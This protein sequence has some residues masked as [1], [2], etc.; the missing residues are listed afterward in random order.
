MIQLYS[1]ED[2]AR[3]LSISKYTVRAAIRKGKL[4]PVRIGRRVLLEL[5]EI[6]N[7]I[8]RAYAEIPS[9][10]MHDENSEIA[11]YPVR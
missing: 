1:V 6:E 3:I 10:P 8:G 2:T 5:S 9:P 7:L 4:R 11:S